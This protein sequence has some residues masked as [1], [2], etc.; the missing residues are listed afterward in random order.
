MN[1]HYNLQIKEYFF[2]GLSPEYIGNQ[3]SSAF[4][5]DTWQLILIDM[6]PSELFLDLQKTLIL[7]HKA[8]YLHPEFYELLRQGEDL[9]EVN[10][11]KENTFALGLIVLEVGLL[12][13]IESIYSDDLDPVYGNFYYLEREEE[14]LK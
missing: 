5:P 6:I 8:I 4:R 3:K 7:K 2:P 13:N 1:A 12:C 10:G 14:K 9:L 11:Y